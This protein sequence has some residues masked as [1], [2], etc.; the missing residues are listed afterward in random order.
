ME[1]EH[2]SGRPGCLRLLHDPLTESELLA[3]VAAAGAYFSFHP[4]VRFLRLPCRATWNWP[5]PEVCFGEGRPD[6]RSDLYVLGMQI[7]A[8][9]HGPFPAATSVAYAQAM[10]DDQPALVW[11]D[12]NTLSEP[13]RNLFARMVARARARRPQSLDEL[14]PE[15]KNLLGAD[16]MPPFAVGS[17]PRLSLTAWRAATHTL[18]LWRLLALALGVGG[19]VALFLLSS[20]H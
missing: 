5:A 1:N 11:K 9:V 8:L 19:L 12:T 13:A 2:G 3:L 4:G 10:L 18:G 16:R 14:Q 17:R 6:V 7:T 20:N 15:L